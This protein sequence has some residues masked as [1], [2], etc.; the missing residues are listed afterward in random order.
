MFRKGQGDWTQYRNLPSVVEV[1]FH[2]DGR[3][4]P[5]VMSYDEVMAGVRHQAL[6]ALKSAYEQGRC[7]V[8]LIHGWSTSRIGKTTARSTVRDLMRSKEATPY[9]NRRECI[10]HE[11]VFVAAIRT[12]LGS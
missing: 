2:H 10:Q 7:Y 8:L 6:E 12:R 11:S 1:D 5:R 3:R 9:I 4:D